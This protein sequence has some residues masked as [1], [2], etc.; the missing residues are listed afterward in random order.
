MGHH[1]GLHR[2]TIGQR[3]K[4]GIALGERVYVNRLDREN[5]VV[6]VAPRDGVMKKECTLEDIHWIAGTPPADT[7]G[8]IV[9]PR[10]RSQG[11]TASLSLV[12]DS[13]GKLFFE[14]EQFAL[15]PGQAAVF[16]SGGEVLGGGWID[17]VS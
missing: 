4:L 8:L 17:S 13:S 6:E 11:G 1:K 10:Y 14:Q 15:T 5:N 2:F 16:Y 12:E 3:G 7:S 9:R